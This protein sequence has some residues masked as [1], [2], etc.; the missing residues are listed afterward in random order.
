M[1]CEPTEAAIEPIAGFKNFRL[2]TTILSP[3]G[4]SLRSRLSELLPV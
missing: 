4:L 2:C 3:I 1:P